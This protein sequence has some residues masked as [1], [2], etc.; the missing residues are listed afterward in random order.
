[1]YSLPSR[2]QRRQP[3]AF[4]IA[5]GYGSKYFTPAVTPPGRE[6]RARFAYARDAFVLA[7]KSVSA[8]DLVI[9]GRHLASGRYTLRGPTEPAEISTSSAEPTPAPAQKAAHALVSDLAKPMR[10]CRLC[11]RQLSPKHLHPRATGSFYAACE[12][13][14]RAH[15]GKRP[16]GARRLL[17]RGDRVGPLKSGFGNLLNIFISVGGTSNPRA[18]M[19]A[20]ARALKKCPHASLAQS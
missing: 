16:C 2:S 3:F 4:F 13:M 19:R 14:L 18:R 12:M 8:S 9:S 15:R 17:G 6:R 7:A 10:R 1:M 20:H 5:I 11:N